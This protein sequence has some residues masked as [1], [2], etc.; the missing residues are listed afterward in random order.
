MWLFARDETLDEAQ[1]RARRHYVYEDPSDPRRREDLD[2]ERERRAHARFRAFAWLLF[3][4]S[5]A[6]AVLGLALWV[7]HLRQG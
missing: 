5:L 7:V 1:R 6:G 3:G 4:P 2:D